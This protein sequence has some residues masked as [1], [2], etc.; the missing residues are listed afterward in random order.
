MTSLATRPYTADDLLTMEDGDNYELLDGELVEVPVGTESETVAF[1]TLHQVASYLDNELFGF[2]V[3]PGTTLQ[4]FPDRPNR[5]PRC[6]GG[7]IS[8]ERLPDGRFPKGHLRVAPDLVIESVSPNDIMVQLHQKVQE[9]LS[10]GV[11]MVWVILPET[12]SVEIYRSDGTVSLIT[13]PADLDGEDVI[14]GFSIPLAKILP[15]RETAEPA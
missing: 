6:D 8:R 13:D 12:R 4:I 14:P 2:V 15:Q 11:R 7:F 10:A 9:Y 1:N 5:V 3:P